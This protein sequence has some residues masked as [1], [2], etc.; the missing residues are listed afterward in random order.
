M[1]STDTVSATLVHMKAGKTI[2]DY[3]SQLLVI[4][5]CLKSDGESIEDV[6]VVEKILRFLE[7]KFEHVVVAIEESKDMETLSI[8]ELM[9]FLEVHEQR[10]EK[11]SSSIV[12]EQALES[13]LTLREEKPNGSRGGYTNSNHGKGH[14]RG[15]FRGRSACR[16][17]GNRNVQCFNCN[18]F[19]HYA[20]DC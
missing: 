11:Y 4:V 5:N 3:F 16:R 10:M 9:G 1:A 14:G 15:T 2:S 8:E 12:I 19:E 20:L 6:C 13:K 18:K 7:N 17:G